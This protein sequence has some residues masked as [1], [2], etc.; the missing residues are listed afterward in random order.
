MPRG[1][2]DGGGHLAWKGRIVDEVRVMVR[3][4]GRTVV[5]VK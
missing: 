2:G 5:V 1:V 4:P 3:N